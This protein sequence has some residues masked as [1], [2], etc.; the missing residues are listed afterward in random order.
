MQK[1]SENDPSG[2]PHPRQSATASAAMETMLAELVD[3]A[4]R[5]GASDA[6]VVDAA[7]IVAEERL[8]RFCLPP[9]CPHYGLS[10]GCPPHVGGPQMFRDLLKRYCH[11]LLVK[12]DT[13][14]ELLSSESSKELFRRL[15]RIAA[16]VERNAAALGCTAPRAICRR[17][18]PVPFLRGSDRL[19]GDRRRRRVPVPRDGQAL[20]FRIRGKCGQPGRPGRMA[21][22]LGRAAG[23]SPRRRWRVDLRPDPGG[24]RYFLTGSCHSR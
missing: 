2:A 11:G 16:G 12:I 8:A 10:A 18:V 7:A 3:L 24:L 1:G 14:A 19:P 5:L 22:A 17:I 4:R 21:D 23:R 20:P 6:A 9:G 13:S 15:H